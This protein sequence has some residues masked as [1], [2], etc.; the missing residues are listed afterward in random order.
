MIQAKNI[1]KYYGDL[2]VLKGVDI[3]IKKGDIVSIV[4]AS[5]AGK[6][7]LLHILGTLDKATSIN[8]YELIINNTNIN[9]LKDKTLAKFRNEHIGFIFQF[10][11]LLPEF[12]AIENVC[13]PA[14]IKGTKKTDAEK[15]AKELLDF[16]GLSQRYDHKPNELSGGEQ[17]RVAVARALINNPDLIFADE[18]SGNLDSESAENLHNL[19]FKLRDEFGQT[20]VIVTHNEELAN[21]ADRKLTMVDGLIVNQ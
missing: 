3:H 21:M 18:P 5:G 20:F 9:S 19:F 4:G 2:Q 17:Q 1:H 11:Q 10:H 15:R 6:T 14:F 8:G 13:L 16:L 12:T 7:T